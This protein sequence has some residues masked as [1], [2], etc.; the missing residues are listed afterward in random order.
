MK[1]IVDTETMTCKEVA[2]TVNVTTDLDM[3][4]QK[5]FLKLQ[6]KTGWGRTELQ[7]E[8]EQAYL[9]VTHGT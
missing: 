3:F 2:Q 9:E 8:I 6:R 4:K 1:L 7:T 5:I